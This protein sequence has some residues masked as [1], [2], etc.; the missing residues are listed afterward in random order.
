[1]IIFICLKIY[2]F[3]LAL[4]ADLYSTYTSNMHIVFIIIAGIKRSVTDEDLTWF[5][6]RLHENGR[7]T[8]MG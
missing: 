4:K 6:S 1:M 5:K 7:P 2:S 3:F 8:G